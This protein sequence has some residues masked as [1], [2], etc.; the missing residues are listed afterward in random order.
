MIHERAFAK[1]NLALRVG[2]PRPDGL[3]PLCSIFASIDLADE[4]YVEPADADTV[5]C[6]DVEGPNL[7]AA[8]LAAFRAR[9]PTLPPLRVRIEKQISLAAGLG[10]G[11]ADAAA[12]LRLARDEV[13]GIEELAAELGADVPG[14]LGPGPALV[15]GAGERVEPLPPPPEYGVVLI[16]SA[17]GLL[18]ADVYAEA[19]RLGLGRD[20]AELDAIGE[21]LRDAAAGGSPLAYPELLANDLQEAALSLRPDVGDAL[22]ALEAAGAARA[23]VT[24]S[25]PTAFGLFGDVVLADRA[26]DSLPPRYADAIVAAPDTYR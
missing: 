11:S 16:P 23:L 10:G 26:A 5:E 20:E 6:P 24:G 13:A 8:A 4:V 14:Q 3:H 2:R 12:V 25:G 9:V 7:A 18:T 17:D 21:R 1:L 15:R 19:D 22:D